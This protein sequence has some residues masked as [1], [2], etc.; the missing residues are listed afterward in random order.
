MIRLERRLTE[1]APGSL[2]REQ[3]A[4]RRLLELEP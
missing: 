3:W 1:V 2:N 4:G